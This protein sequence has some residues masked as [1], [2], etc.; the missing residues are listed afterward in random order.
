M[1]SI[2]VT[3]VAV[4]PLVLAAPEPAKSDVLL[5]SQTVGLG[6]SWSFPGTTTS[7]TLAIPVPAG[8]APAS[9]TAVV[10]MPP[11]VDHGTV[12]VLS[13]DRLL[14]RVDL[15]RGSGGP[16]TLRI[17]GARIDHQVATVVLRSTLVP[18]QGQCLVD[19]RDLPM[20]MHDI[21][22]AYAGRE[23]Q[24]AV[25]A[26]FLPPTLRQLTVYLPSAPSLV[27]IQAAAQVATAIIAEYPGEPVRVAVRPLGSGPPSADHSPALLERQVAV[28]EQ[29][30]AA[31]QLVGAD[32]RRPLLVLTG[33]GDRLADQARLLT[34]NISALA[35]SPL[36]Q[37]GPLPPR[38]HL[39]TAA[40]TFHDLGLTELS[41]VGIGRVSVV[42]PIDQS[43]LAGPA[44]QV[45]VRLHGH[46]T[47]LP[48]TW[49]GRLSVRVA[50]REIDSW[51]VTGDGAIDRWIDLPDNLLDRVTT[52]M[53]TLE[54]VGEQAGCGL[55]RPVS[56]VIDDS[57]EVTQHPAGYPMPAGFAALP[58]ALLPDV[59]FGLTKIDMPDARR[60]IA[61]AVGLQRLTNVPLQPQVVA[62]DAAAAAPLPA[63][64]IAADGGVPD[65]IGLP[66]RQ[67]EQGELQ[68]AVP[69]VRGPTTLTIRP[70]IAFGSL[71]TVS[72]G[73]R[74]L[75][76]ATSTG[77]PEQLDGILAWLDEDVLR[78]QQ[79]RG[80][81]LFK[82][83]DRPPVMVTIA[84]DTVTPTTEH[85]S[86]SLKFASYGAAA[87]LA[88]A[89]AAV[90]VWRRLTVAGRRRRAP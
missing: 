57:S 50:D 54:A 6:K 60:A 38:R 42:V 40:V 10:N 35:V 24:P 34:S 63:V 82:T 53:V 75:L 16:V 72:D 85:A 21:T 80:D 22:V 68:L 71:Q 49:N 45:R 29:D 78:W 86:H 1:A 3:F 20:R 12:D 26:D 44:H 37:A 28:R 4:A 70:G 73:R 76:V 55:E 13:D 51:P 30:T 43:R 15:P 65:S 7:R 58:Q 36:A 89:A 62:F 52:M 27:E 39:S 5:D 46:Y 25:I 48:S 69:E 32:Q 66:L 9:I 8:L 17:D 18:I 67:V 74:T 19:W 61:I 23:A 83:V 87:I 56:L 14:D 88:V 84:I 77:V 81:V 11:L 79:L 31:T 59:R 64:L 47:P 2:V 90:V 33:H 41:N